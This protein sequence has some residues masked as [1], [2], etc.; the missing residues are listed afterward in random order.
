MRTLI[1]ILLCLPLAGCLKSDGAVTPAGLA[2]SETAANRQERALKVA[3]YKSLA[4][5]ARAGEFITY[6]LAIDAWG[7]ELH[8]TRRAAYEPTEKSFDAAAQPKGQYSSAACAVA[9]DQLAAGVQ[10]AGR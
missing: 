2:A 10:G 5:R 7:A 8:T 3:M 6:K 4:R 1:A 9:F